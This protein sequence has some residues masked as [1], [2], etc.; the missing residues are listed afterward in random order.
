M[1]SP[2]KLDGMIISDTSIKQPVLITMI[3]LLVLVIG[4]LAYSSLPVNLLPDI[5]IPTVAVLMSYP[6]AG[7]ESMA[8][9][10]AKPIED[11]LQTLNGLKH[12][13]S[14]NRE[15]A[16]QL[17]IEFNTNVSVDRGLQDVRDKVNAVIPSLPR[18]VKDPV[19]FKFD[20][21]QSPIITMAVS[22]KSGRSPLELRTLIDDDIVPRLQQAQGVGAITVNGGQE[23]QINVQMDLNK[24]K[25]WRILP[26]Q[27]TRAIQNANTNKGLGTI[28]ADDK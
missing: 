5:D 23:R 24:L 16:T 7:P 10:V 8:D 12:I 14:V 25:A 26:V 20:P 11:Q 15:G 4:F 2:E 6:G 28:T 9:Q 13:T 27:I 22:S 17:I 19:F 18:D 21:N 3:M 1:S